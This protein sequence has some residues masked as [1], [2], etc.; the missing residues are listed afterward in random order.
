MKDELREELNISLAGDAGDYRADITSQTE[1]D[2][3]GMD[4]KTKLL[5]DT[6]SHEIPGSQLVGS[7][8]AGAVTRSQRRRPRA[9]KAMD[10]ESEL[11][12]QKEGVDP[13]GLASLCNNWLKGCSQAEMLKNGLIAESD[14]IQDFR[15]MVMK[16]SGKRSPLMINEAGEVLTFPVKS[17]WNTEYNYGIAVGRK[18][19][20]EVKGLRK[21]S[22]LILT[23]DAKRLNEFIPGW[24]VYGDEEFM[25]IIGGKMVSEFLRKYRAYKKKVQEKNNFVTWVM[26]FHISGL[27]HFHMLFYGSWIAPIPVLHS[28]WPYSE[29][30]GIRFGKRIKHQDNGYVLAQYLTRYITYDLQNV[31][32]KI[33][34]C[35]DENIDVKKVRAKMERIKAFLWFFKRRLYNLRHHVKNSDGLYTLGIGRDQYISKIKWKMYDGVRNDVVVIKE[36]I[37]DIVDVAGPPSEMFLRW[38]NLPPEKV[39]IDAE[40]FVFDYSVLDARREKRTKRQKSFRC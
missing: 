38:K 7:G 26:E 14:I 21:V 20:D 22:H 30:N 34:H 5:V 4:S 35:K 33:K 16:V 19:L 11:E 15:K 36:V 32:D 6:I 40:P 3:T 1:L 12:N 29:E 13:Y 28:M 8:A 39:V 18:A 37:G 9:R 23:V 24:W 31:D 25:A 27:V 10:V 2:T 17:R